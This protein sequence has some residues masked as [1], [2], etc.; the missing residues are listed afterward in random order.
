MA[1]GEFRCRIAFAKRARLRFLSHLEVGHAIE[2]GVRRAALPYAVTRGFNPHMK[3]AYGPALPVGTAGLRECFD[4]WL[5]AYIPAAEVLERFSSAMPEGLDPLEA[6]Y[7]GA[8]EPSLAA[9]CTIAV[10]EILISKEVDAG[11]KLRQALDE[12]V[13]GGEFA[14]EHKGKT[15]VFDLASSLPK[16]VEVRSYEG[17][18]VVEMT[19]RMGPEGSLRPESLVNAALLRGDSTGAVTSVTRR[20]ILMSDGDGFR[21]PI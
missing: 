2:R 8:K 1:P 5:K 12:I 9:S 16:E 19:T 18:V 20:D 6:A 11:Q 15:K 10:Y 14:V 4:V 3:I 17:G 13:A 7:V 21:R